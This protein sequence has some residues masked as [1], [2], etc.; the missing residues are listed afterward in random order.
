[1]PQGVGAGRGYLG[2]TGR[3]AREHSGVQ[4]VC[5]DGSAAYADAIRQGAP[6][7]VQASHRWH[8]WHGL[9]AAAEKCFVAHAACW[10]TTPR[11]ARS[12]LAA[13]T[14]ERH[15][16]VH[17][18]LAQGVELLECSRCLGCSLNTVKR[19]GREPLFAR[20]AHSGTDSRT[21]KQW[22]SAGAPGPS[23]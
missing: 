1:M 21:Y 19:G 18:L 6:T 17:S 9:A 8:L 16:A 22:P 20:A 14:S 12:A 4:V 11:P 23:R 7:A 3:G 13:R 2:R 5:R 15:A 10:N